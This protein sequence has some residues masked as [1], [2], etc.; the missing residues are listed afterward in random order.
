MECGLIGD[1]LGHSWSA[2]IHRRLGAY[3]YEA[4][5]LPP[6]RLESFFAER[7]WRA[8]N[9][10]MP[11]K[12]TVLPFCDVLSDEVQAIGCT[13]LVINKGGCLYAYNT[14][15]TGFV[16][17]ARRAGVSIDG[18]RVLI[19]GRGGAAKAVRYGAM[20]MGA[21]SVTFAVRTLRASSTFKD[22]GGTYCEV[23]IDEAADEYDILVNASP[24]GL[25]SGNG[26]GLSPCISSALEA[27]VV[28]L[29]RFPNL[30]AVLD[31]VY[32][33][34]KTPLLLQARELGLRCCGG[35]NMLVEQALEGYSLI[36]GLEPRGDIYREL[37]LSKA[38][39]V[40][41]GMPSC[42]KTSVGKV[43][44]EKI[45]RP[46]IDTDEVFA[47]RYGLSPAEFI[48]AYG[49][50]SFRDRES[51]VILS[52]NYCP[53]VIATGGGAVL[54][55]SNVF[56]L[57]RNGIVIYLDT[58]LIN[59]EPSTSRPLS[60]SV[61]AMAQMF[62]ERD[63]LYRRISDIRIDNNC[64]SDKAAERIISALDSLTL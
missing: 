45:G 30:S 59:L 58:D 12:L 11:Y 53:A 18:K 40:L 64:S 39:I 55:S 2:D 26:L 19:I 42:G 28:D 33:P 54:R 43:L 5:E 13:N 47:S 16:A 23:L 17:M 4:R 24:C 52:L 41:V 22:L 51:E 6:D 61:D 3:A 56:A 7:D 60:S 34:L 31:V 29:R 27:P 50:A 10:T 35:L 1:H 36:T 46:F 14:D 48:N 25:S 32:N 62:S 37:L 49:E 20:L 8:V 44:A 9:V 63:S 15:C 38:D 57:S 21:S